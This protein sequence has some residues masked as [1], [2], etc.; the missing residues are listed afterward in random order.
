MRSRWLL[1][2]LGMLL[3]LA[4][5]KKESN[6]PHPLIPPPVKGNGILS[7]ANVLQSNMVVQ[8][9]KPFKIWGSAL[10]AAKITVN[11]SWNSSNF[12]ADADHS[13]NWSVTVPASAANSD[14]QTITA[15]DGGA[16][17]VTLNN[18]LIG[19]VWICSG[20]SNMVYQVD[21]I[22]PF[23]GVT[24]YPDEIAAANFPLIR[25]LT[26]QTDMESSPVSS[27]T[28][29]AAWT[30]CSPQT[31]GP[32]SGVAYYFARKL[33]TSLNVPVGIIIS[34]V[35]GTSCEAWI[36]EAGFQANPN[37]S[38]YSGIN[39]A[40]M[41]YNGMINP[42]INLSIKGFTWYQ[43][44]NNKN[45][46]PVS[47]YTRLN[48]ALIVAWR[49]AFNQGSLPFYFVQ[50]TPFDQYYYSTNPVGGEPSSDDYAKFREAQ[51]NV[52]AVP[53]TGMAITMDVGEPAN[54][55]PPNKKPVGERLA[56]L[57]LNNTY[58]Q[59]VQCYG[60]QYASYTTSG[61]TVTI[62]FKQ[63]TAQG[64]NTINNSPLKQYFF[65]AGSNHNFIQASAAISGSQII[66][67]APANASLPIQAVRYAFTVAPVTNLQ[68]SAALPMEP[69]RTD[70]WSN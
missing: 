62:S 7:I 48:S 31:V 60:P 20:Q 64:L 12:T 13:G 53:N 10:A 45:N 18:I 38:N 44:E 69:F 21:S 26:I 25:V 28:F 39:N 3:I 8:R 63:G 19:D 55:H 70:N 2:A 6:T 24:D 46:D 43:G 49:Q 41:Y 54:Q 23:G 42:L 30:V 34:A 47:D 9:D 37:L 65:V 58:G 14:P 40:T 52:L 56:L 68:N 67:T 5:C 35:N 51:A 17:S 66:L 11:V 50:M 57:A 61:N 59:P 33:Y 22:P 1:F 4:G 29:P 27:L 36:N 32:I 15:K 16:G